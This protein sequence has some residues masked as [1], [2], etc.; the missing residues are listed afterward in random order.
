[1]LKIQFRDDVKG[2]D[3][4]EI[5]ELYDISHKRFLCKIVNS[6]DIPNITSVPVRPRKIS[7]ENNLTMDEK[8]IFSIPNRE[9]DYYINTPEYIK[10]DD[11]RSK[12][13]N[14]VT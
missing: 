5:S 11:N 13:K 4:N 8:L 14:G 6:S 1:M 9:S 7:K 3:P 10:H 2:M 12:N